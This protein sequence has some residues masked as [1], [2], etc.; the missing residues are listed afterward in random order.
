MA[1]V[2]APRAGER[3][4]MRLLGPYLA[5]A[6]LSSYRRQAP[7]DNERLRLWLPLHLVHLWAM[8]VADEAGLRGPSRAGQSFG[9]GLGSWARREFRA[10]MKAV[11]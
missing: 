6:Y 10:A 7:I 5:R 1:A 11:I 3:A 9:P 4:G 2:G 8:I